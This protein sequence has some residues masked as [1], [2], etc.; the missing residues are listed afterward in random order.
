MIWMTVEVLLNEVRN[1]E[2]SP[3]YCNEV[4]NTIAVWTSQNTSRA[5]NNINIT[6]WASGKAKSRLSPL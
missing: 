5:V 3:C 1:F 2:M 6:P 4:F